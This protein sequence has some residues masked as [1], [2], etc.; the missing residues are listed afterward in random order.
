MTICHSVNRFG[1]VY[2]DYDYCCRPAPGCLRDPRVSIACCRR[3]RVGGLPNPR[4]RGGRVGRGRWGGAQLGRVAPNRL[5]FLRRCRGGGL[6]LPHERVELASRKRRRH[7]RCFKWP[8]LIRLRL[9]KVM[10]RGVH[11][12]HDTAGAVAGP[13]VSAFSCHYRNRPPPSSSVGGVQPRYPRDACL[14]ALG[15]LAAGTVPFGL[16]VPTSRT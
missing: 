2:A 6:L 4:S 11:G 14:G 16:P 10:L 13:V 9:G 3:R 12:A 1:D 8:W 7:G 15:V 5:H